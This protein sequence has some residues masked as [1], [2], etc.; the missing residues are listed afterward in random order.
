MSDKLNPF[1]L[2]RSQGRFA[3][4]ETES[5][6]T[7]FFCRM[8]SWMDSNAEE[9]FGWP[10]YP[11]LDLLKTEIDSLRGRP[12]ENALHSLSSDER[13]SLRTAFP[14]GGEWRSLLPD[15]IYKGLAKEEIF[16]SSFRVRMMSRHHFLRTL[17]LRVAKSGGSHVPEMLENVF[18]RWDDLLKGWSRKCLSRGDAYQVWEKMSEQ[19]RKRYHGRYPI[20]DLVWVLHQIGTAELFIQSL[21]SGVAQ[22]YLDEMDEVDK[23]WSNERVEGIERIILDICGR[24]S[25]ELS[26]EEVRDKAQSLMERLKN[27]PTQPSLEEVPKAIKELDEL[28]KNNVSSKDAIQTCTACH[29]WHHQLQL[30]GDV[31]KDEKGQVIPR[32][33][34]QIL[35]FHHLLLNGSSERARSVLDSMGEEVSPFRKMKLYNLL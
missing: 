24:D 17:L 21:P 28:Q 10:D 8:L 6:E 18:T 16:Y 14:G 1:D 13:D 22:N 32:W 15:E 23:R 26:A 19:E 12:L 30:K 5:E 33:E 31:L 35:L 2:L 11:D 29:L 20:Q 34:I 4:P 27:L 25:V 7:L 9:L 3:A